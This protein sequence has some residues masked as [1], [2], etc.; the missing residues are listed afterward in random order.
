[1]EKL[2]ALACIFEQA[3]DRGEWLKRLDRPVPRLAAHAL[4][5]DAINL[6]RWA[7]ANG[8]DS[9]LL[10]RLNPGL[11]QGIPRLEKPVRILAP[12]PIDAGS[13]SPMS[14]LVVTAPVPTDEDSATDSGIG[15]ATVAATAPRVAPASR[16]S[17]TVRSGESA[18]TIA[19][20]YG[21]KP[22]QLLS[23]NGLKSDSVLRPGMVLALD[24]K[25]P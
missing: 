23:R 16:R 10:K 19:R 13:D 11:G 22:Q 7:N 5:R 14:L 9:L 2:H 6:E 24:E 20:R 8:H 15:A 12:M 18:W 4:P 3:D 25:N 17:H 21:L 1:V